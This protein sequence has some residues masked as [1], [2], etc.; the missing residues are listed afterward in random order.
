[1]RTIAWLS[2]KGGVGK[3][4]SAIN[5]AVGLAKLGNRVLL[6]DADPQGNASLVLLEGHPAEPPTL[7]HVLLNEAEAEDAIRPTH[8]PGLD[9]LPADA[10]LADANLALAGELGRERRLRLAMEGFESAY[11]F[12][13][14][15]T[16][17]ARSLLNV[18]VLNYVGEVLVPLDPG[19]FS[20][21]GLAQLRQVVEQV[22]RFLDNRALRIAGLVL[23]RTASNNVARD[24]EAQVRATF[25]DLVFAT[26]IPTNAKVEEAHSRYQSVLDY[27][28]RSAGAKA[29][30]SL[31]TEIIADGQ[32]TQNGPGEYPRGVAPA[33]H[34]A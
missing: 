7:Y 29:Y 3:S 16:S 19:L 6:I 21:S 2:E 22:R 34:A 31:V 10:Q 24:I 8:V 20:L 18:N 14:L 32:R 33:D 1:M 23:T 13:I 26:T 11:D 30:A 12:V 9:I 25:G 4:T 15:D 28:P 17:P 27:A 5:S